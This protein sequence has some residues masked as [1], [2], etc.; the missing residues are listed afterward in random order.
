MARPCC[1]ACPCPAHKQRRRV[2]AAAARRH[3]A[4]T[5]RQQAAAA[6]AGAVPQRFL[7][8]RANQKLPAWLRVRGE[9]RERF[10]G[11]DNLGFTEGATTNT[12]S[13]ACG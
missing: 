11:F 12:R 2:I 7:F 5:G 9:F 10:E 4:S 1:L 13:H 8:N 3:R 6:A